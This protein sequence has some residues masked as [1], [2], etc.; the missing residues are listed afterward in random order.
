[1]SLCCELMLRARPAESGPLLSM[2]LGW[3]V[4]QALYLPGVQAPHCEVGVLLSTLGA[5]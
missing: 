4:E 5:A 1:M 2:L 3:G